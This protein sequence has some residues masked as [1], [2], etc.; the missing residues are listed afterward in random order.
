MAERT[1]VACGADVGPRVGSTGRLRKYCSRS[2]RGR[3]AYES[4]KARGVVKP[5]ARKPTTNRACAQCGGEFESARSDARFCSAQCSR[6]YHRDNGRPCSEDGCDQPHRARGLCI[7]HYKRAYPE[8]NP[9]CKVMVACVFCGKDHEKHASQAKQYANSFCSLQCRDAWRAARDADTDLLQWAGHKAKEDVEVLRAMRDTHWALL[10]AMRS[11]PSATEV[12]RAQ[13]VVEAMKPRPCD[14]CGE[15][16]PPGTTVQRYCSARC[17]T[18]VDR[19]VRRAREHGAT[20]TFTWT[21]VMHLFLKFDRCCAYC[22]R[23]VRGQPDPDHVL[24]LSRGGSNSASNLLPA[25]RAC[26]TD[27]QDLTLD[28]WAV[29]RKE[30]DLPPVRTTWHVSDSRYWHLALGAPVRPAWR[31]RVA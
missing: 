25:C 15:E 16:Y 23:P 20:G 19:R 5:T 13:A 18:R 1:C 10:A 27:K 24:A 6:K 29:T 2:C 8:K 26:N 28:E 14:D 4:A 11:I 9:Y 7:V 12:A 17:A 30:R 22:D 31:H 21:E 3:A